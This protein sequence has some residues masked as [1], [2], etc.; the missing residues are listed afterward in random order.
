MVKKEAKERSSKRRR[1][2]KRENQEKSDKPKGI[3]KNGIKLGRPSEK[4]A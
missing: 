4:L 1:K 2:E 3:S